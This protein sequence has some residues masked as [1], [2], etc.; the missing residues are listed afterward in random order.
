MGKVRNLQPW[1]DYFEMLHTYEYKG[2]IELSKEGGEAFVT[3]AALMTLSN[4]DRPEFDNPKLEAVRR[5]RAY[6]D[7]ARR[8]H[9]YTVWKLRRDY[10]YI[11]EPFA[12][13]VV[14]DKEP[15]DMMATFL[16][17]RRRRWWWP[18]IKMEHFDITTYGRGKA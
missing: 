7:V 13:H 14:M 3:E 8:I 16:I 18:F 1:L 11:K 2:Y 15:H 6:K 5:V 12:L 4:A 9:A 17:T 10:D